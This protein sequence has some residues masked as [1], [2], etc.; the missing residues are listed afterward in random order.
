MRTV[1]LAC[2]STTRVGLT[3]AGKGFEKTLRIGD[4]SFN[5]NLHI[6]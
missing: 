4:R 5:E 3:L 1:I 2:R 6:N